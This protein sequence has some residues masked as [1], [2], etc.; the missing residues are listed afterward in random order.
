MTVTDAVH[1][2]REVWDARRLEVRLARQL[3]SPAYSQANFVPE[4]FRILV[5]KMH[6][7][8]KCIL[9]KHPN[10]EAMAACGHS[11]LMLMGALSYL[12]GLPQIAV[13]KPSPED[14]DGRKCNGWMGCEGFLIV[15]DL[16]ESGKTF[17]RII[18]SIYDAADALTMVGPW[19]EGQPQP[20]AHY[21]VPVAALLYRNCRNED[22]DIEVRGSTMKIRTYGLG[23]QTL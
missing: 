7:K 8:L 22:R 17:A 4:D 1:A 20:K 12:T 6:R 3:H 19:L 5:D 9:A 16:C 15:D 11:G 18:T 13:R 10:I 14:H 2:A 23:S 21:P